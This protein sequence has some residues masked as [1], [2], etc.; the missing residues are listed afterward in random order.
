MRLARRGF[1]R[2]ETPD[3]DGT[4]DEDIGHVEGWPMNGP[5]VEVE[6]VHHSANLNA[7]DQV[8]ASPTHHQYT[9][10]P[11][12][13]PPHRSSGS[14][15]RARHTTDTAPT[16]TT[17]TPMKNQRCQPPAS[18]RNE[19]AAP[20][21]ST[22]TKLNHSVTLMASP[23]SSAVEKYDLLSWSTNKRAATAASQVHRGF[24][25]VQREFMRESFQNDPGMAT[26]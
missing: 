25:W 24:R 2:C 26:A 21:L 1:Q 3:Q 8:A 4:D 10:P 19:N 14:A 18:A 5:P 20:A 22:C 7:V 13:A 6:K 23:S 9:P 11:T 17:V 16:T 15:C 12:N